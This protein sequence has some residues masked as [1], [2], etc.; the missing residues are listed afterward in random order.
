M[1]SFYSEAH[2]Q[3]RDGFWAASSQDVSRALC[4][5]KGPLDLNYDLQII[6]DN[7]WDSRKLSSY[8]SGVSLPQTSAFA[9]DLLFKLFRKMNTTKS[10][11]ENA[12]CLVKQVYGSQRG[13]I[14]L[15]LLA[16]KGINVSHFGG[17]SQESSAWTTDELALIA[18]TVQNLPEHM[19]P[20]HRDFYLTHKP[21][22]LRSDTSDGIVFGQTEVRT[23]NVSLFG[24][25]DRQN[26]QMQMA[27]LTH[28]LAHTVAV[29]LGIAEN[30]RWLSLS[31]WKVGSKAFK[32]GK[33][34][35]FVSQYAAYN[36]DEDFAESFV[37]YRYNPLLLKRKS[38]EKFRFLK[39]VVFQ[40]IDYSE[41]EA[42]CQDSQAYISE[43]SSHP[44]ASQDELQGLC[45][46][47]LF[48]AKFKLENSFP[49][50]VS[51]VLH[52]LQTQPWADMKSATQGISYG[53]YIM[54]LFES[55]NY[56]ALTP[57][58]SP[59]PAAEEIANELLENFFPERGPAE[60][61]RID[62][63]NSN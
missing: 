13:P 39:E 27:I 8:V 7:M 20:L 59:L 21:R 15:W 33:K 62:L 12:W 18:R 1:A 58:V 47:E 2:G 57:Y 55:R 34:R 16:K 9:T 51:C 35:S 11:C 44:S 60:P 37:A 56:P 25:W 29:R 31:D 43:Y 5:E 10:N 45:L 36:P 41:T 52:N 46:S 30:P 42:E 14:A 54:K 61:P 23:G 3:I 19:F 38:P 63:V 49:N 26:P 53:K 32:A 22:G 50:L 6:A 24:I 40:G 48:S 28:E 4:T 17:N